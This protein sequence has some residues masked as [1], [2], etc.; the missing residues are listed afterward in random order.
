[1]Q[2][3]YILEINDLV[4][5]FP[6]RKGIFRK[7]VGFVHAVNG[8]SFKIKKGESLGL[9]G[10]SG[11]GKT[12]M[13]KCILFLHKPSGGEI[14]FEGIRLSQL[15]QKSLKKIRPRFQMVFQ[16]PYS[17]L[18]PR[19]SVEAML[20]EPLKLYTAMTSHERKKRIFEILETVGLRPE[21]SPR[22]PHEFSGG[23][24]QRLGIARALALNP[25]LIIC[26][27]PVSA[28]DVSIQAQILNL[29]EKLKTVFGLSYL[30]ISHDIGVVEHICDRIAIMYL[31][32]I[33]ELAEDTQ[34]CQ[35]PQHPYTRALMTSIP[36]P[37][38]GSRGKL[39]APLTGDVPSPIQLPSGCFF[40]P[41]CPQALDRCRQESP[42]LVTLTDGRQ[43]ACHLFGS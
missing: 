32:K 27:E 28:L 24:R 19:M 6:I 15:D 26:D 34:I 20:N 36:I 13:G 4:K 31:G 3:E 5:H 39:R 33:V 41:R 7:T 35:N 14:L 22:Y 29:L 21:H 40:H 18:N 17:T 42:N 25:S 11:C 10:E 12:T 8:V 37:R 30:F 16:D 1:M 2:E 43:I 38:S 9:V 23:Q